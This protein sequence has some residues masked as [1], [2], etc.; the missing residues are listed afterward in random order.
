MLTQSTEHLTAKSYRSYLYSLATIKK[1]LF[2]ET[3]ITVFDNS[4]FKLHVYVLYEKIYEYMNCF[5]TQNILP[6]KEHRITHMNHY[7]K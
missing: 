3:Y 7:V 6:D 1:C 4:C 2:N 5:A